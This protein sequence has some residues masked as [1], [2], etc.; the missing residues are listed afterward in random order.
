MRSRFRLGY[1][2]LEQCDVVVHSG[3]HGC[4]S[5]ARGFRYWRLIPDRMRRVAGE[6]VRTFAEVLEKA[7][8][9]KRGVGSADGGVSAMRPY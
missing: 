7:R 6:Y 1:L 3:S 8:R 5:S 2:G 4:A 9:S